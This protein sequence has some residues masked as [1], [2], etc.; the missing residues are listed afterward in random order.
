MTLKGRYCEFFSNFFHI[1]VDI[2]P[3]KAIL[4]VYIPELFFQE[5]WAVEKACSCVGGASRVTYTGGT[6]TRD[7]VVLQCSTVLL[8]LCLSLN[9]GRIAVKIHVAANMT[10]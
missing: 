4:K 3:Q 7:R 10:L 5:I 6:A 8:L 9:L 2:S 1:L